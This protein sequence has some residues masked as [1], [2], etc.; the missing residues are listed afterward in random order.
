MPYSALN[1]GLGGNDSASSTAL[2]TDLYRNH[3]YYAGI[4]N[5]NATN[6]TSSNA[7][8]IAYTSIFLPSA[9]SAYGDNY[10]ELLS[11][12]DKLGYYDQLGL[13][14]VYGGGWEISYEQGWYGTNNGVTSCGQVG[15]YGIVAFHPLQTW[16]W[17][18]FFLYLSGSHIE[19]RVYNGSGQMNGTPY[20]ANNT[21]YPDVASTFEITQ[22]YTCLDSGPGWFSFT[23]YQE[24]YD[25]WYGQD[26]PRWNFFFGYTT[27]AWY[28]GSGW[29]Y[30][31]ILNQAYSQSCLG[32]S[33]PTPP[34]GYYLVYNGG[35]TSRILTIANLAL[36]MYFG[37]GGSGTINPGQ[38]F[39]DNG[40][41]ADQGP[42]CSGTRCYETDGCDWLS[43]WSGSIGGG[44]N[45]MPTTVPISFQT[46][47][48]I[49]TSAGLY[50][51]NCTETI[52][53]FSPFQFSS[54]YF[55]I[56]VT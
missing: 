47:P 8:Q 54:F 17:Y 7:V 22:T 35:P 55:Y 39:Y 34:Q 33:C 49:G 4:Y 50:L 11:V 15:H 26:V 51:V 46:T 23:D 56:T 21:N 40:T 16:V 12:F 3:Y 9:P 48:P 31:G 28:A 25:V 53:T 36:R 13:T 52:T 10:V 29:T 45:Y 5:S 44:G 42:Y 43:G 14:P 30:A 20:W 41:T 37:L 1:A 18:T 2:T 32:T 24:A 38:T 27:V 6:Y 19:F